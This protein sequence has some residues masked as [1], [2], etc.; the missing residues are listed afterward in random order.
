MQPPFFQSPRFPFAFLDICKP[1]SSADIQ[2]MT[3]P[4][5]A[6]KT[7][8]IW[9]RLSADG[10]LDCIAKRRD[11]SID[12]AH[13]KANAAKR[14]AIQKKKDDEKCKSVSPTCLPC[15]VAGA[16]WAENLP[17]I[18]GDSRT[19]SGH[20][21]TLNAVSWSSAR[22]RSLIPRLGTSRSGKPRCTTLQVIACACPP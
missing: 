18:L 15:P 13:E 17:A 8:G 14:A 19:A 22:K 10:D 1:P 4:R 21:K 9:G 7:P 20:W 3:T 11:A 16:R 5:N 12:A 6:Q 2:P